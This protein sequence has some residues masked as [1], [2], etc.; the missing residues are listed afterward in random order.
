[1]IQSAICNSP[2]HME[3]GDKLMY[4]D[5]DGAVVWKENDRQTDH[6]YYFGNQI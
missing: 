3:K 1:M 4:I 5:H 2:A 6:I